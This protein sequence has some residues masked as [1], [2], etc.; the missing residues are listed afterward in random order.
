MG[1]RRKSVRG[2][3]RWPTGRKYDTNGLDQGNFI[4]N[5][6]AGPTNI[7][8]ADNGDLLVSDFNGGAIRRF[9]SQGVYLGNFTTGLSQSEGV[10]FLPDGNL[11]IGNGGTHSVRMYTPAGT[12]VKDIIPNGSGGLKQPNAVVVREQASG[13]S[14]QRRLQ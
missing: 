1:Q 8:F 10:D 12:Y 3:V 13:V 14:N 7:W 2:F 9:N 4:S 5:N 11:L 6:L